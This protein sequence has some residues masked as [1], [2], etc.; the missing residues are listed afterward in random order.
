MA[1]REVLLC[2]DT[3]GLCRV[4]EWLGSLDRQTRFRVEAR[5]DRLED[6]N[7]GD[8]RAVGEGL[9]ELRMDFGPGY[10]IYLGQ[11]GLEVHLITAGDKASQAKD[12]EYAREFWRTHG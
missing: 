9:S 1:V 2:E 3:R 10:R 12:I 8:V 7:F 4:T 11:K 5:I 6:G